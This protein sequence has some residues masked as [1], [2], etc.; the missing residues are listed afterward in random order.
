MSLNVFNKGQFGS[1]SP[2]YNKDCPTNPVMTTTQTGTLYAAIQEDDSSARTTKFA[3]VVS[4]AGLETEYS[5]LTN[6]PGYRIRCFDNASQAGIRLNTIDLTANDFFVMIHSDDHLQHHFAKI[7]EVITEDISGDSFEFEPRL[8]NEIAKDVKFMLFKLSLP[9]VETD[10]PVALSAGINTNLKS[11]LSVA[12]PLFYF[13]NDRLDKKNELNHNTKYFAEVGDHS[14][15]GQ[16][17]FVD[18][19]STAFLTTQD[20]Y[21]K[22][23]DYGPYSLNIKMVDKLRESDVGGSPASQEGV[24]LPSEDFADYEDV[25]HNARR[26]LDDDISGTFNLTGPIRYIHYDFSP[27]DANVV[28]SVIDAS[29]STSVNDQT[30]YAQAEMMDNYRILTKKIDENEPFRLRQLVH[31]A[32]LDDFISTNITIDSYDSTLARYNVVSDFDVDDTLAANDEIKIGDVIYIIQT[33]TASTIKLNGFGRTE[34]ESEFTSK[35]TTGLTGTIFVRSFNHRTN[36]LTTDYKFLA[37][38]NEN[39]YVRIF[40]KSN[41]LAEAT[42]TAASVPEKTLTL[43][44]TG[45]SYGGDLLDYA[46]GDYQIY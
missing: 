14:G 32:S 18:D 15:S 22:I 7:T 19:Q 37:G 8:G 6:T 42:V 27:T 9:T 3:E 30:G 26:Q 21:N 28:N 35:T 12:R 20:Y 36:K 11:E 25:F 29:F 46:Y 23:V 16:T 1:G 45:D 24:T 40:G 10:K 44:L 2:T 31:T 39:L 17:V 43:S 34:A 38:R 4:S 33:V 41:R 13:Y 5:N